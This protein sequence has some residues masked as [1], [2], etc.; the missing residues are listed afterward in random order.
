MEEFDSD[1]QRPSTVPTSA[2]FAIIIT[3]AL[4]LIFGTMAYLLY[5]DNQ[6]LRGE[7]DA[8]RTQLSTQRPPL[9]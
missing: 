1:S 3:T 5:K 7:I 2:H 4:A 6:E 8:L 9:E